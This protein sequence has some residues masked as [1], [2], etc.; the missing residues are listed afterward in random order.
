[1][2]PA[3][4]PAGTAGNDDAARLH[5]DTHRRERSAIQLSTELPTS[6][7][8]AFFSGHDDRPQETG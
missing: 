6:L 4:L 7:F 5:L 3:S 8:T 2:V 1:M